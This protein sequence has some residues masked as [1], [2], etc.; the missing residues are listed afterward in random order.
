MK[1]PRSQSKDLKWQITVPK[2][3]THE[4]ELF[5]EL[6]FKVSETTLRELKTH[7][8][9]RAITLSGLLCRRKF[10]PGLLRNITT[11]EQLSLSV[12]EQGC[13]FTVDLYAKDNYCHHLSR[14]QYQRAGRLQ[15]NWHVLGLACVGS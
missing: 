2:P 10:S 4:V 8:I 12:A 5:L 6:I 7:A 15:G 13:P 9:L 11:R 14:W 3:G 1:R